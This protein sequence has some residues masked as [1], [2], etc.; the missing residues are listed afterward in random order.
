MTVV[1]R[2]LVAAEADAP[3][4]VSPEFI[5]QLA[6]QMRT[7]NPA[8]L[9]AHA[10]TNATSAG[11]ASI[12][13]WDDPMI[14]L[15]GMAADEMMR[16]DDGDIMYG[17]E[18]KLPLFGKATAARLVARTELDVA[19]ARAEA[20]F[21]LRRAGLAV[22][23]FRAGL[24]D[25]TIAFGE[26]DLQWLETMKQAT[27]ARYRSGEATLTEW[28][29]IR[30]ESA[31]RAVQLQTDRNKRLQQHVV[32]NRMLGRPLLQRW[33][34]FKLPPVAGQVHY[35]PQLTRFAST[36][37]PRLRAMHEESRA[38]A[39]MADLTRRERYPEI[40]A[41]VE[42][43]NYSG[44]GEFRQAEIVMRLSL[45]WFNRGKYRSA[46]ERDDA[47]ARAARLDAVDYEAS[48]HEEI[49]GLTVKIESAR[50]EATVYRD[51]IIP[52]SQEAIQSARSAW[53]TGRGMFRDVLEARRMLVEARLMYV[54]SVAEQY[55]M[56]SDL[57]LCCGLGD[58]EALQMI[59]AEPKPENGGTK[60]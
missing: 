38:A 53:E 47:K 16:A 11:L 39:A 45:P 15:G 27:D 29:Q 44:N 34:R 7:N 1:V 4:S 14:M 33:P 2:N 26:E 5:N 32:I 25:E 19:I 56:L 49:H 46:V 3:V 50:R 18:Q 52:G 8:L 35:T 9:A 22:A 31:R 57:V 58:L 41:G 37:E 13:T 43:R 55:E 42:A 6:E 24:A 30:N 28:L 20:E 54:R 51:E 59:G 36:Y 40:S 21:Q 23:F 60:P 48:L 17:F 10:R 12:R